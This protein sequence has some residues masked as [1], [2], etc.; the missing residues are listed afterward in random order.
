MDGVR[1]TGTVADPACA[2]RLRWRLP[3]ARGPHVSDQDQP[4]REDDAIEVEPT[5]AQHEVDTDPDT[6]DGD[7]GDSE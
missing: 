3:R 4:S 2:D 1:A 5:P 6:G 7:G